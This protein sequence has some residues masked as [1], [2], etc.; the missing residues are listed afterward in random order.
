MASIS[1]SNA[2]EI[3]D[4]KGPPNNTEAR[5]LPTLLND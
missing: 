2:I 1:R 5:D 4:D 3:S